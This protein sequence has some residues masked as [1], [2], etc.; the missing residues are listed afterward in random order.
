MDNHIELCPFRDK[1]KCISKTVNLLNNFEK[2]KKNKQV[3]QN[4]WVVETEDKCYVKKLKGDIQ[5]SLF[6]KKLLKNFKV[7]R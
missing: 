3:S 4:S 6:E 7:K 5:K 2:K 1:V